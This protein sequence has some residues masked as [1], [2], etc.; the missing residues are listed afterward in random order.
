MTTNDSSSLSTMES[1]AACSQRR[2]LGRHSLLPKTLKLNTAKC[3]NISYLNRDYIF[4]PFGIQ[5]FGPWDSHP[6]FLEHSLDYWQSLVN[7][8][9]KRASSFYSPDQRRYHDRWCSIYGTM[10]IL[11]ALHFYSCFKR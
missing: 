1:S 11:L 4:V 10:A 8:D 9:D 3:V 6:R 5:I 2:R 7:A